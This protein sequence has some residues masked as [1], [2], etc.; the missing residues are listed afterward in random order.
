MTSIYLI[1]VKIWQTTNPPLPVYVVFE[2]PQT[3]NSYLGAA[4]KNEKPTTN[5]PKAD[6]DDF[7]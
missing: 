3:R 2:C 4:M 7:F 5:D 6:N 1:G